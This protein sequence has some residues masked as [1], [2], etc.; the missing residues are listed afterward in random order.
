M[1]RCNFVIIPFLNSPPRT[2][3]ELKGSSDV[4]IVIPLASFSFAVQDSD[5]TTDEKMIV[6]TI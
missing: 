3:D 6:H 4:P 5:G 1:L 2:L